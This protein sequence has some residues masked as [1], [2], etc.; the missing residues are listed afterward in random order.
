MMSGIIERKNVFFILASVV[1]Y[2]CLNWALS[3]LLL[4]GAPAI[5]F[6]P[7][8]ILPIV[9]GL[10]YGP[11]AG[12]F[13]GFFGNAIGDL[14]IG[15]G[16]T[17]WNWHIANGLVGFFPGLIRFFGVRDIKTIRDFGIVQLFVIIGCFVCMAFGTLSEYFLLHRLEFKDAVL[18]WMLPGA[19]VNILSALILVPL[20]LILIKRLIMTFETRT[21]LLVFFLLI[22]SVLATTTVL[23]WEANESLSFYYGV[24]VQA[25]LPGEVSRDIHESAPTVTLKLLR[26]AGLV[27][28]FVLMAGLLAALFLARWVTAPVALLSE[29][30]TA[31]EQE[32]FDPGIL[33]PIVHRSDE[34]GQL[35]KTFQDMTRKVYD[36]EQK[37]K[38]KIKILKIEIDS[39]K[40]QRQIEEITESEYFQNLQQKAKELREQKGR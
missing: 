38:Q 29:S 39:K 28:V 23:T 33:E 37:M 21:M 25:G 3:G 32:K 36:R 27:S 16:F 30:A 10:V 17:Y 9:I 34:F 7:Q 8:I 12:F 26:W 22:G 15:H 5:A 2:G 4:P 20:S 14:L 13:T 40:E 19:V 24:G 18:N 6:R 31:V 35:A 11:F 1:G